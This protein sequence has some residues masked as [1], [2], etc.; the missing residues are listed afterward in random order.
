MV[1]RVRVV[2]DVPWYHHLPEFQMV[3]DEGT[4]LGGL[5]ALLG[6]DPCK[7]AA[8]VNGRDSGPE[9]PLLDGDEILIEQR[10]GLLGPFPD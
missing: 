7:G 8:S 10:G 5:L 3:V 1:V 4:S 6:V 9:T 2:G